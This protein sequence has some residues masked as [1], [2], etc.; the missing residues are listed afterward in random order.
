MIEGSVTGA[1]TVERYTTTAAY[2]GRR[3]SLEESWD[4]HLA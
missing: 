1:A 3:Q 2:W 4:S